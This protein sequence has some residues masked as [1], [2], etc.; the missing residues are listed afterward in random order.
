VKGCSYCGMS[1]GRNAKDCVYIA[2]LLYVNN[3][4][5]LRT[6]EASVCGATP[7]RTPRRRTKSVTASSIN[8]GHQ[9]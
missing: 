4:A 6:L 2:A 3:L 7:K 5:T 9:E 1:H 8:S